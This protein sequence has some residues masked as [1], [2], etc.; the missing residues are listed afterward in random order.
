VVRPRFRQRCRLADDE[1][2]FRQQRAQ[3]RAIGGRSYEEH[4]HSFLR[5]A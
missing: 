2:I 4:I 3:P 1:Q 5:F